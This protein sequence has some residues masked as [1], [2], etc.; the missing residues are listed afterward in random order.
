MQL[1][2]GSDWPVKLKILFGEMA[3]FAAETGGG[4]DARRPKATPKKSLFIYEIEFHKRSIGALH[5]CF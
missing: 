5:H 3:E 2:P 4:G 1:D